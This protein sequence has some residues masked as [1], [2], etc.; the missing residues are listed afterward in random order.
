[1]FQRKKNT[2]KKL[3]AGTILGGIVGYL[4][5]LLTAPQSGA[6]TREDI[7]DQATDLKDDASLELSIA[8]DKLSDVIK[9]AQT[10]TVTLSAQARE[11]FNESLIRAKDAQTKTKVILKALKAGGSDD[12]E[13]NKAVKQAKQAAKNLGK[14][15]KS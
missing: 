15:I 4:A 11:E 8:Y 13:L 2:G 10:K 14:F 12:P 1:M 7:A 6:E 9:Q 5:G 3:A